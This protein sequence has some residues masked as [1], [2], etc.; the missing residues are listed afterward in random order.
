[1]QSKIHTYSI[2]VFLTTD[3]I[4]DIYRPDPLSV[5]PKKQKNVALVL[6]TKKPPSSLRMTS[7]H[8]WQSVP[9]PKFSINSKV[10]KKEVDL[11]VI[12]NQSRL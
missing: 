9:L 8:L 11:K 1:M 4:L 3:T 12:N 6:Y 10:V 2:D 5:A 7:Q